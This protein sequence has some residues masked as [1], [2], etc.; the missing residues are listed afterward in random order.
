MSPECNLDSNMYRH[1]SEGDGNWWRLF[2][3]SRTNVSES[4][5][6]EKLLIKSQS[7]NMIERMKK[8][9]NMFTIEINT[10]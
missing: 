7:K 6:V 5:F 4:Q 10:I 3:D 2:W 9:T 8:A 1:S